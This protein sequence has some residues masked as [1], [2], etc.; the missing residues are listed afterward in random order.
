MGEPWTVIPDNDKCREYYEKNLDKK[1]KRDTFKYSTLNDSFHKHLLKQE[2]VA[3]QD[4]QFNEK[5]AALEIFA[6]CGRN[7]KLLQEN[8]SPVHMLERNKSMVESIGSISPPVDK[9]YH[10]DARDMDWAAESN[11]YQCIFGVWCLQYL[12]KVEC[13]TLLQGIK[14][15]LQPGGHLILFESI[16]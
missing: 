15:S 16:L 5:G 7:G 11:R 10:T 8:F 4:C 13:Q 6:G 14:T 3:I 1:K 12:N 2:Q 9:I